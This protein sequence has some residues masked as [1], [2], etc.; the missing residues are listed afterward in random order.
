MARILISIAM[1]LG[2][3]LPAGCSAPPAP[4]EVELASAQERELRTAG[5]E[6]FAPRKFHAYLER[7]G[8]ARDAFRKERDRFAPFVDY[9]SVAAEFAAV[10]ADGRETLAEVERAKREA[11]ASLMAR[12]GAVETSIADL[13]SLSEAISGHRTP[14][15][16]LVKADLA[17]REARSLL[18]KGEY[19]LALDRVEAAEAFTREASAALGNSLGRYADSAQLRKWRELVSSAVRESRASGSSLVVVNKLERGLVLYEKGVAVRSY[20]VGIGRNSSDDKLR[21]GDNATPEGRYHVTRK[22]PASSYHRALL[23]NYPNAEDRRRFSQARRKGL[24]PAGTSIG[25]LVEIHGGGS[26]SVTKGCIALDNRDMDELYARVAV[27]TPVVIVGA[28]ELDR[29]LAAIVGGGN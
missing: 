4:S 22:N 27:G 20:R 1:A 8:R 29:A 6:E 23:I 17:L 25:G 7:L 18:G 26:T 14:R 21:S 9:E 13:E 15:K 19:S 2:I 16:N 24:V 10:L 3:L 28:T 12:I 5:A 11:G